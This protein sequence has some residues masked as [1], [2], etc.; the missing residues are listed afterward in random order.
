LHF[1]ACLINA[2]SYMY[3]SYT[4]PQPFFV[5]ATCFFF[6]IIIPNACYYFILFYFSSRRFNDF[7]HITLNPRDVLWTNE[8]LFEIWFVTSTSLINCFSWL[9]VFGIIII[10]VFLNIF[11]LKFI[12]LIFLCFKIIFNVSIDLKT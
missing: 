5:L 11:I 8:I 2:G 6:Y 7:D 12:K 3:N 4:I 1:H 10:I 9:A